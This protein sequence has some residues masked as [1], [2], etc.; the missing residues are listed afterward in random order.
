MEGYHPY[1]EDGGLY[2]ARILLLLDP[3]LYPYERAFA[4]GWSRWSEFSPM[5]AGLTRMTHIPLMGL[6]L[7]LHVASVWATLFAAWML[8]SRCFRGR[9]ACA[10][11][12]M[13]LACWLGIPVAGTAL[14]V[15]DPYLTARS[16]VVPAMVLAIVGA[17]DATA[18]GKENSSQRRRG[19][20]L[21]A[22]ALVACAAMHPLM[23]MYAAIASAVLACVRARARATRVGGL[24]ALGVG[25]LGAAFCAQWLAPVE[26]AA[27]VHAEITRGYW[28]LREWQWY[29]AVGLVAPLGILGYIGWSKRIQA[30]VFGQDETREQMQDRTALARMAVLAGLLACVVAFLFARENAATHLV[31]RMQPLRI[32]QPIY[33]VMIVML[34]GWMGARA[35]QR[36]AW[37]WI[38]AVAVLGGVMFGANRALY[39][40][41]D[42]LE[43][44]WLAPSNAWEQAFVWIRMNTPQDALF[45]MD[46][47][48]IHTPGEDA[49]NFRA[50]AERSALPDL[51]K[52]GGEASIAPDLA[53][54]WAHGAAAQTGLNTISD[55]ER[56]ARLQ[57]LGVT[58][59]V[60]NAAAQTGFECPYRNTAVRVCKLP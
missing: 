29:E 26:S 54:E 40:N 44:P 34:G 57:P 41:T 39:A 35:L 1:G 58:W 31:A 59:V 27:L 49:Q 32:F 15:M 14:Y 10:G 30:Y 21:W 25:A 33:V 2:L 42:H 17:L 7:A 52:D 23:G 55:T 43:L 3:R 19:R 5:V 38:A 47:D 50:I 37:R 36:R 16:F 24:A 60:L 48:Y 13:L 8:A 6:V 22:V 28:F 9:G 56:L 4:Q 20:I 18:A 12:V 46:A 45:A 51:S 11:A 53:E